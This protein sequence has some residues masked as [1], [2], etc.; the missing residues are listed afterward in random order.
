MLLLGRK[1]DEK[2]HIGPDIVVTVIEIQRGRVRLGIEA[3]KDVPI[4]RPDAKRKEP[5]DASR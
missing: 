1:V 4:I 5:P 3:P 2:I